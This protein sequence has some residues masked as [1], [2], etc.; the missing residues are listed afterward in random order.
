ME[1]HRVKNYERLYAV[2]F[3][4]VLFLMAVTNQCPLEGAVMPEKVPSGGEC[5]CLHLSDHSNIREANWV[6]AN[7]LPGFWPHCPSQPYLQFLFK[8][9]LLMKMSRRD[10]RRKEM[11]HE[12]FRY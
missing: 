6:V 4:F 5:L 12:K 3:C 11:E 10:K 2:K 8:T 9:F 1:L 7:M